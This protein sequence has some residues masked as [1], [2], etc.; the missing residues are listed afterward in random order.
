MSGHGLAR[1]SWG[2]INRAGLGTSVACADLALLGGYCVHAGT[3]LVAAGAVPWR[4]ME[5]RM[6]EPGH[7]HFDRVHGV[8]NRFVESPVR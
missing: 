5:A 6:E 7:G 3:G 2:N 8:V 1:C 4:F